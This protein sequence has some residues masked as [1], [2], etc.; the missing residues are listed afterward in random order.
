[1]G[2]YILVVDNNP[3]NLEFISY[4]L[5]AKGYAVKTAASVDLGLDLMRKSTPCLIISDLFLPHRGGFDFLKQIKEV[6]AWK[7]IPFVMISATSYLKSDVERAQ[8]LGANK[9]IFRPIEPQRL[10]NEIEPYLEGCSS[11]RSH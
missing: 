8:Q 3:M 10:L 9:F 6:T 7:D 1:M 2:S 11:Q 4:L 5:T